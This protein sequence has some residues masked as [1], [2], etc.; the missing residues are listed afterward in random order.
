MY[1]YN[2]YI[3][4]FIYTYQTMSSES[5]PGHSGWDER[6]FDAIRGRK[7]AWCP[8]NTWLFFPALLVDF[9]HVLDHIV[10]ECQKELSR[11][12]FSCWTR[13]QYLVS[14]ADVVF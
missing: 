4:T 12:E 9:S 8:L 14:F 6:G 10:V 1:M 11:D 13:T 2:T 7:H 3:F 5:K